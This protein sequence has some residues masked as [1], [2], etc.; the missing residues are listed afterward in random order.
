MKKIMRKQNIFLT[1]LPLSMTQTL[2]SVSFSKQS[3]LRR[4]EAAKP[5]GPPPTIKTSNGIDS[6]GSNTG[7]SSASAENQRTPL[8][9]LFKVDWH[10]DENDDDGAALKAVD[11]RQERAPRLRL[12]NDRKNCARQNLDA[13]LWIVE[14]IEKQ[15]QKGLYSCCGLL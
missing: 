7:S 8:L 5:A 6:R 3:C 9:L 1:H 11:S 2:K 15:I 12:A 14:A 4:M 13:I 10:D